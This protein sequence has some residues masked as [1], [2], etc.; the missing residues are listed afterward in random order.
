MDAIS[1]ALY[2]LLIFP[3]MIAFAFMAGL[4]LTLVIGDWCIKQYRGVRGQ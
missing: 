1:E 4:V 2:R 3:P